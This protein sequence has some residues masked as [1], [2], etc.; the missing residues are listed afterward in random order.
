LPAEVIAQVQE[1]ALSAHRALGCSGASRTDMIVRTPSPSGA[2]TSPQEQGGSDF[3]IFVLEVNTL[4]GMTATSLLPNSARAAGIG[5]DDLCV[6]MVEDALT[7]HA[8]T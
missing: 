2:H 1:I 6:W 8:K 3:D 4:P 5:F 7:R